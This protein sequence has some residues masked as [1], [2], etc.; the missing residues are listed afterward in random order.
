MP[1]VVVEKGVVLHEPNACFL[2]FVA[3]TQTGFDLFN[4]FLES[5]P[6]LFGA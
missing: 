4:T 3:S 2:T 5:M 6:V 1:R